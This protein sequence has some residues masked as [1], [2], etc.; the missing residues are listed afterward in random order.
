MQKLHYLI[1]RFIVFGRKIIFICTF[2][3][4]NEDRL[5]LSIFRNTY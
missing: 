2:V 5:A 1:Q 3:V 4:N